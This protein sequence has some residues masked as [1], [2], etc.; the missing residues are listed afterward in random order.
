MHDPS[1]NKRQAQY[2]AAGLSGPLLQPVA[3]ATVT[4]AMKTLILGASANPHR[5]SYIATKRLLAAGHDVLLVGSRAGEVFDHPILTELPA[6]PAGEID[7]IT[8]YLGAPRQEPYIE[9]ITQEL[10]PRRIIF[11]PGAENPLLARAARAVG[12]EVEHACTLVMLSMQ[13][14]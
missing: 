9:R 8:L 12:I 10:I 4:S 1:M 13:T 3:K 7:T 6:L 5:Y 14:Y 2:V 11:N